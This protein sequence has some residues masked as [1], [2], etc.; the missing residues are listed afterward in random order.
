MELTGLERD[1]MF[2]SRLRSPLTGAADIFGV[3]GTV[4]VGFQLRPAPKTLASTRSF[5]A[6]I[7]LAY[8]YRRRY[9][10]IP[11]VAYPTLKWSI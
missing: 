6:L 9:F 3:L 8:S 7:S 4:G 11:D 5:S 2:G 1:F 10:Y